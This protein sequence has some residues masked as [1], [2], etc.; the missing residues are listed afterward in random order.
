MSQTML[1]LVSVQ[2]GPRP[3]T[4][5]LVF[6]IAPDTDAS[7]VGL[8]LPGEMGGFQWMID[9][10]AAFPELVAGGTYL[11]TIEKQGAPAPPTPKGP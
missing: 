7:H 5:T 2:D 9:N 4:K 8:L 10:P 6:Q 3:N 1:T 11:M